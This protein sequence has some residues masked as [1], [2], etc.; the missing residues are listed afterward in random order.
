VST[1]RVFLP[2]EV[3]QSVATLGHITAGQGPNGHSRALVTTD[4]AVWFEPSI[5]HFQTRWSE[6]HSSASGFLSARY[7]PVRSPF[8]VQW[9]RAIPRE[10]GLWKTGMFANQNSA[11]KLRQQFTIEQVLAAFEISD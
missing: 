2:L 5:A 4:V 9:T 7:V 11:A 10:Q 6:A 1:S 3:H 8:P